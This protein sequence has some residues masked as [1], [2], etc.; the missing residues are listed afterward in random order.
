MG[1]RRMRSRLAAALALVALGY[2]MPR[3]L[4]QQPSS[5][6]PTSEEFET[7]QIRPNVFVIV[8]AGGNIT[9][10]LGPQGVILV[11]TG[12]AAMAE[13]VIAAVQALTKQRIR[14]IINTSADADHVGGNDMLSAVGVS[15]YPVTR[16][17][18]SSVGPA[19]FSLGAGILAREEVLSRMSAPTGEVSPFPTA[20]QPTE[21]FTVGQ[22]ALFLNGDGIQVIHQPAAHSD[23]DSFVLFRRADVIATGDVVDLQRFPVIDVERGGS[24]QGEIDALNRLIDLAIP[25][26]PLPW[27]EGRTLVVPGHGR[28][29]DQADLV[30]YRDA[31]TVVRDVIASLMKKGLTL[32]Q[33]KTAN[34]TQGYRRRYGAESGPWTTDMFV[35]A[36]FRSLG[37]NAK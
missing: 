25:A 4:A 17:G 6:D 22:R 7:I 31:V 9:A 11:D 20:A 19:V 8:G 16:A 2:A 1:M 13:K 18:G 12:A 30:E 10:H 14:Y 32:E 23:G 35:E 33:V 29:A 15:L 37:G 27:Q 28:I 34:P 26:M 3:A 5:A 21:T 24:V 36:V